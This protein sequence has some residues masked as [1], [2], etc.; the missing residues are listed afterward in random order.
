[1]VQ[2]S[3]ISKDKEEKNKEPFVEGFDTGSDALN[4][5]ENELV[6]SVK[7][8]R[9]DIILFAKWSVINVFIVWVIWRV[10]A[11]VIWYNSIPRILLKATY[12]PGYD[13]LKQ[14]LNEN[15]GDGKCADVMHSGGMVQEKAVYEPDQLDLF[16]EKKSCCPGLELPIPEGDDMDVPCWPLHTSHSTVKKLNNQNFLYKVWNDDYSDCV[17]Y[18]T[19]K[20]EADQ[21]AAQ[22]EAQSIQA[23]IQLEKARQ[24]EGQV[25]GLGR[26][27][28]L[29]DLGSA[30]MINE[31][32]LTAM[33]AGG[34]FINQKTGE[35]LSPGVVESQIQEARAAAQ[36]YSGARWEALTGR[37]RAEAMSKFDFSNNETRFD[38]DQAALQRRYT[39]SDTRMDQLIKKGQEAVEGSLFVAR[40]PEVSK[41]LPAQAK[42]AAAAAATGVQVPINPNFLGQNPGMVQKRIENVRRKAQQEGIDA[43]LASDEFKQ[44]PALQQQKEVELMEKQAGKEDKQEE[45]DRMALKLNSL[46][47]ELKIKAAD[48][49]KAFQ[50]S[51]KELQYQDN[52]AVKHT[53]R[54]SMLQMTLDQKQKNDM[55][56]RLEKLI[57]KKEKYREKRRKF[58]EKMAEAKEKK[59]AVL[60]KKLLKEHEEDILK[61]EKAEN[62]LTA[63]GFKGKAAAAGGMLKQVIKMIWKG[64]LWLLKSGLNLLIFLLKATMG[65]SW[66]QGLRGIITG[67]NTLTSLSTS[68]ILAIKAS[69]SWLIYSCITASGGNIIISFLFATVFLALGTALVNIVWISPLS[70]LWTFFEFKWPSPMMFA[71]VFLFLPLSVI[72]G[73]IFGIL[74]IFYS[75][76]HVIEFHFNCLFSSK[77]DKFKS[78]LKGCSN[79][80]AT[81]RR[82]FFILT[83]INA[84]Q[85]LDPKVVTGIILCF[86]YIEYKK[87]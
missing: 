41:Y 52:L 34:M 2:K 63:A 35:R 31:A 20:G 24:K 66:D 73:I 4:N 69:V 62:S 75:W 33:G 44:L 56:K 46:K 57:A 53:K 36:E 68:F 3:T 9:D 71:G 54:L 51:K 28:R 27:T 85:T 43:A 50:L 45:K 15:M 81:L 21:Q 64:L 40:P 39:E 5:V 30:N 79:I 16:N 37:T 38:N 61:M 25:G 49:L 87:M 17:S 7:T 55:T 77:G 78:Q 58:D 67:P 14:I 60:A 76:A 23:E 29:S 10:G 11:H 74:Y 47:K 86:L 12:P 70:T 83:I 59:D 13:Y 22:A 80:Q 6:E 26:N 18:V 42:E 19:W 84:V 1:M 48:Q 72:Y 82:L 32:S 65:C 8:M